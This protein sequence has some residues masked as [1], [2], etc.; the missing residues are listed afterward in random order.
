MFWLTFIFLSLRINEK[1]DFTKLIKFPGW[2]AT[3]IVTFDDSGLI[4]EAMYVPEC[5]H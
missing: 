2:K 3:E 4:A 1:N 5:G